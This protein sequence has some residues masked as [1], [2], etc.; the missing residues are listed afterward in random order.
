[1]KRTAIF[2]SDECVGVD[3]RAV[4]DRHDQV[5]VAGPRPLGVETRSLRRVVGMAV[6]V[7]HDVQAGRVRLALDPDVIPRVDLVTVTGPVDDDVARAFDLG[8]LA[9]AMRTDHD[10]ADLVRIP[11]SPM[12]SNGV[13]RAAADLHLL[14]PRGGRAAKRP[15]WGLP[16]TVSLRTGRSTGSGRPSRGTQ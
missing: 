12:R 10:A 1:M 13:E 2:L 9:V 4:L 16:V 8:D 14:P 3:G 6:V 5:D 11:L 7:A 15:G